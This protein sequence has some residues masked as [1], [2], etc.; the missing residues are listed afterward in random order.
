MSLGVSAF[1]EGSVFH[2]LHCL[3]CGSTR[4]KC[5][6]GEVRSSVG[7]IFCESYCFVREIRFAGVGSTFVKV[8][9]LLAKSGF[10]GGVSFCKR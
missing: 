4:V 9:V 1:T 6:F 8:N 10:R 7:V 3:V 2:E 5:L